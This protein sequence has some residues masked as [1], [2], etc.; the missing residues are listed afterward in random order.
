MGGLPLHVYERSED[1][2]RNRATDHPAYGLLHD[3]ANDWTPASQFREQITLDA[4]LWGNGY[5]FINR[6]DGKPPIRMREPPLLLRS[7]LNQLRSASLTGRK[8]VFP[9]L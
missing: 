6:V 1:G 3:L 4:L 8:L 7:L 5:G 9:R 2:T